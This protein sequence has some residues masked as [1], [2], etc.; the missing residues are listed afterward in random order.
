MDAVGSF[1][2]QITSQE[3][4]RT[5]EQSANSVE[6]TVVQLKESGKHI[7]EYRMSV[8]ALNSGR[9]SADIAI[10]AHEL[11]AAVKADML[12]LQHIGRIYSMDVLMENILNLPLTLESHHVL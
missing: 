7:S 2:F 6:K 12:F 5:D 11:V 1:P 3:R 10:S 9:L 8:D 4:A